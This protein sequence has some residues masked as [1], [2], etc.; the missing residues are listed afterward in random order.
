MNCENRNNIIETMAFQNQSCALFTPTWSIYFYD[1][2]LQSL[3]NGKLDLELTFSFDTGH[4]FISMDT[5]RQY[6]YRST[7]NPHVIHEDPFYD[8]NFVFGV[9]WVCQE[10][11]IGPVVYVYAIPARWPVAFV[12]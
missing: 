6:T 12:L 3:H 4:G 11:I 8:V 7:E 1:C 2:Y 9:P 5:W 10:G